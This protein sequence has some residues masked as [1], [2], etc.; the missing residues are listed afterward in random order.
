MIKQSK[1]C[2][3]VEKKNNKNILMTE[4]S[5]EDFKNS[6]KCWSCDNDYVDHYVKVRDHCHVIGKF[7]GL[8]HRDGNISLRLNHKVSMVFPNLKFYDSHLIM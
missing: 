3:K 2:G 4:E 8:A 6:T 1:Y 7:R 5:N